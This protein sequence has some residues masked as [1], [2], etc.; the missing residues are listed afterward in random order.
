MPADVHAP[1][2]T[3]R[4]TLKLYATLMAFLP[5]ANRKQHAIELTVPE[6]ATIDT[7]IAPF[8]MP[9]ALVFLVLVNGVFIPPSARAA[10]RFEDGDVL[11]IW[12][13]VAGG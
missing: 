12:P 9:K 8:G 3:I 7:A 10:H 2:R 4:I 1:A 11:A 6:H 13:P 5:E